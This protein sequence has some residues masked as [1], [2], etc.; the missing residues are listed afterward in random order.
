MYQNKSEDRVVT[1]A[2]LLLTPVDSGHMVNF[3]NF[4]NIGLDTLRESSAFSKI[5]NSSKVYNSHLVHS[6]STFTSKYLKLNS[7]YVDENR[8]LTASSFGLEK[9]HNLS[10]T[11]ALGN[12]LGSS[13]LDSGS[14]NAFLESNSVNC[15]NLE[16]G[17]FVSPLS[18]QKSNPLSFSSGAYSASSPLRV[19]TASL[20]Q[21]QDRYLSYPSLLDYLNDS[22]DKSGLSYPSTRLSSESLS[23]GRLNNSDII[24]AQSNSSDFSSPTSRSAELVDE[25]NG[26]NSRAFN[27]TGPNSKVLAGDQSIRH[28]PDTPASKANLNLSPGVNTVT[29]NLYSA[30]ALNQSLTPFDAATA[31]ISDYANFSQT[32]CLVEPRSFA[33]APHPAVYG[34][35]VDGTSSLEYDSTAHRSKALQYSTSGDLVSVSKTKKTAVGDIFAGSREKTPRSINTAYWSTF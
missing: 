29:S 11:S 27:L 14:F 9:Q 26:S 19:R 33:A 32:H 23:L 25:N 17:N 4:K 21:A 2:H 1:P 28:F 20:Q 3:L 30:A 15:E 10:S 13:S 35:H 22:S 12:S 8:Y 24:Y 5:R 16:Y 31:S 6:P 34:V 18:L 7:L